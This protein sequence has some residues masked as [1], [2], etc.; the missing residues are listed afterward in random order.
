LREAASEVGASG[1]E[2]V[3]SCIAKASHAGDLSE[4]PA[5]LTKLEMEFDW[6][7]LI[8][9]TQACSGNL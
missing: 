8:L 1:M 2:H 6:L 9:N 7:C 3:L 4:M 5:L